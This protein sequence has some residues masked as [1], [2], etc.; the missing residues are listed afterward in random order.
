MITTYWAFKKADI[1][2]VVSAESITSRAINSFNPF[3]YSFLND[4]LLNDVLVFN[5]L[6]LTRKT[7]F[8][9]I[10]LPKN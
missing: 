3:S 1:L 4:G 7:Y 8:E 5:R 2:Y 10:L 9:V 6:L